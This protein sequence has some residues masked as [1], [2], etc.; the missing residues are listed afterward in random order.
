MFTDEQHKILE[1]F[2]QQSDLLFSEGIIRTDSFTGEIGEYF[3]SA[4]YNFIRKDRVTRSVDA[5]DSNNRTYQ[6][7]SKVTPNNNLSFKISNLDTIKV[8]FLCVIYFDEIYEP[9]KIIKIEKAYFPGSNFT[10]SKSFL[11]EINFEETFG[12][13]INV[14]KGIRNKIL[15]FG[16]LFILL[17]KYGVV[18]SRRIVG[19]IGEFYACRTLGLTPF[20]DKTHKG[21]DAFD[22]R[23]IS[24]EIKTRRVYQSG[25][26]SSETRRLNN[27]I[28]KKADFLIVVVL[29]KSF[30][31]NGMWKMPLR[32]VRNPKSA[33]LSI[34]R[35]TNGIA[36]IIPTTIDWLK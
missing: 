8:D 30:R 15:N 27:L 23:G 11:E 7:K 36:E 17:K 32:N 16:K 10:L 6:I 24:Y 33:T 13:Q 25:R 5:I 35:N 3:V 31:C 21:A 19:D 34:V 28:E 14:S 22:D 1:A 26:R 4:H 12:G 9:I 18:K 20:T 2:S 29:D